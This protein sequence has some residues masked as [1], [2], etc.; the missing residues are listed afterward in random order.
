MRWFLRL[1]DLGSVGNIQLPHAARPPRHW[2][3]CRQLSVEVSGNKDLKPLP[4]EEGEAL[5]AFKLAAG[6]AAYRYECSKIGPWDCRGV[7][8]NSCQ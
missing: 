3:L 5:T 7:P 8:V 4:G 2:S 1:Q 6:L